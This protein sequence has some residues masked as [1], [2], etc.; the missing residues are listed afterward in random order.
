[1]VVAAVVWFCAMVY[2]VTYCTLF[3]YGRTAESLTFV[4]G[5]PDWIFWG[6]ILPW[7]LCTVF[8]VWFGLCYMQDHELEEGLH[9]DEL[10]ETED[11]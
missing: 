7:G 2:S 11:A 9:I 3:G 4:L 6:V 1:M 8:S 10:R 5:F